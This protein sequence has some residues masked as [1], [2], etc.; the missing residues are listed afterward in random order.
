MACNDALDSAIWRFDK[1]F[2]RQSLIIKR[3]GYFID[4]PEIKLKIRM[5]PKVTFYWSVELMQIDGKFFPRK[6]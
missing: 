6:F 3:R 1:M 4:A 2:E 5:S